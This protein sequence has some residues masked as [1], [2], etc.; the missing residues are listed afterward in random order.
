MLG[1]AL[2]FKRWEHVDSKHHYLFAASMPKQLQYLL[3]RLRTLAAHVQKRGGRGE[4]LLACLLH[5]W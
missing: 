5:V 1:I 2:M 3:L 4:R